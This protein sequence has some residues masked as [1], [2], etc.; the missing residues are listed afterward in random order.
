MVKDYKGGQAIAEGEAFDASPE[1]LDKR[2][3]VVKSMASRS[4]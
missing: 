1:N 2:T 3:K 4:R